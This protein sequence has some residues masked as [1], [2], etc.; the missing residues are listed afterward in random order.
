MSDSVIPPPSPTTTGGVEHEFYYRQAS[1]GTRLSGG[2]IPFDDVRD[3]FP[4]THLTYDEDTGIYTT[5]FDDVC[6]CIVWDLQFSFLDSDVTEN[7]G[8]SAG[9]IQPRYF[10]V[11]G[12]QGNHIISLGAEKSLRGWTRHSTNDRIA[13]ESIVTQYKITIPTAG[14]GFSIDFEPSLPDQI[15]DLFRTSFIQVITRRN[16]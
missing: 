8:D 15:T 5:N 6:V 1:N 14:S 12:L 3:N 7:N 10:P 13:Y 11:G 2:H 4:G 9:T 16:I